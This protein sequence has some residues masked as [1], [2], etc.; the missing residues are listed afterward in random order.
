MLLNNI[1]E[2]HAPGIAAWVMALALLFA[3]SADAATDIDACGDI[4]QEGEYRLNRN[5]TNDLTCID[6]QSGNVTLD[7]A[8]FTISGEG[9]LDNYGVYVFNSTMQLTNITLSNLTVVDWTKGIVFDNVTGGSITNITASLNIDGISLYDSSNLFLASN[10][11]DQNSHAGMILEFSNNN[12][13]TGNMA[14]PGLNYGIELYSSNNNILAD[15]IARMNR[16][17]IY[18]DS[19]SNNTLKGNVASSNDENG[20]SLIYSNSSTLTNNTAGPNGKNGVYIYTANYN[21][22]IDNNAGSNSDSGIYL[23]YS[24][25]NILN[26][27]AVSSNSV[28]GIYLE[29]S[30][31]NT[32][33]NNTADSNIDQGIRL[34]FSSRNILLNNTVSNGL[35]G[36][37]VGDL[38]SGSSVIGNRVYNT[39]DQGIALVHAFN[40]IVSE[41]NVSFNSGEGILVIEGSWNNTISNN[42]ADSNGQCGGICLLNSGGSIITNNTANSNTVGITLNSSGGNILNN[43]TANSNN[44][45]GIQVVGETASYTV[46]EVPFHYIDVNKSTAN[47]I[48]YENY[49]NDYG[50][51]TMQGSDSHF[52]YELPF[53]F[54]FMGRNITRISANTNGL[55]ELLE[56]NEDCDFWYG[57][58]NYGTHQNGNH[59]GNMDA[60][61]ASNGDL[62]TDFSEDT[63]L[64]VFNLSDKVV[65]EWYGFTRTD[66]YPYGYDILSNPVH[67]QVVIYPNG[68]IEWN[69]KI[70]N[71]RSYDFDMFTGVYAKEENMEIIGGYAVDTQ[72]SLAINLS[73]SLPVPRY[74]IIKSNSISDNNLG[75]YLESSNNTIYNNYLNNSNNAVASGSNS[76]NVTRTIGS[77]I[78]DGPYLG[79]NFWA[80]PDGAGF[81]QLCADTNTDGICDSSYIPGSGNIDYLALTP[82]LRKTSTSITVNTDVNANQTIEISPDE[83]RNITNSTIE[84][85]ATIN[86]PVILK[87]NA[88]TD[89]SA[90]NATSATPVY[91]LDKNEQPIGRYIEVNVTGIDAVSLNYVNLTMYYTASDLDM[92]GDGDADDPGDLNEQTL[93]IYWY[94][95]NATGDSERWKPLGPGIEPNPDYTYIGGPRVLGGE[96]NTTADN[97]KVTLNHFSTFAL[98]A[99]IA[100]AGTSPSGAGNSGSNGGGGGVITSEPP[101]NI[102][103]A[104]KH[105]KNVIANTP[106]AYTFTAPELGIYEIDI[107]GK[108]SENDV[109]LRVEVLKGASK[110]V[111]VSPPGTVYKNLNVWAGSKRIK[112]AVIK[113]RVGNSWL[114]SSDLAAGDIRM[115]KWDGIKWAQLDTTRINGDA[116][117]VYYEATTDTFSHFAISGVK[118]ASMPAAY[119]ASQIT[120]AATHTSEITGTHPE[121]APPVRLAFII[122]V[123]AFI[124]IIA[125]LYLRK[126]RD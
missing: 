88:S 35:N 89:A 118:G 79:G 123:F 51:Y 85:N 108:E 17:G 58:G 86:A 54:P 71:F 91:G 101:G 105:E 32:L 114:N 9:L 34:Y 74:N 112:G 63:Y 30:G 5:L 116:S 53:A 6:I 27:N 107:T 40:S 25:S 117:Y 39:T 97:L 59:I 100:S 78:A 31:N 28:N 46:P 67:F 95:P 47:T 68:I 66:E 72:K 56:S 52:I 82:F 42:T 119:A 19:S 43:N 69:F 115:L 70:M 113:F 98:A 83:S 73:T 13:I 96:R 14:G 3:G 50:N 4:I 77:N 84:L 93:K 48:V 26:N 92:N 55:I 103:A 24:A 125:Y 12:I 64:G 29:Y 62:T 44:N 18:L 111:P 45:Y 124:A 21:T 15:N 126:N 104:E 23:I 16:Y 80:Q 99:E 41:N 20:I 109:S 87:I 22:L 38:S 11:L 94:N 49:I 10:V 57:C 76:L 8:G 81:S 33:I 61:F 121:E 36:I 120:P 2:G 106:V 90:L 65:V 122:G 102:A 7:G 110:L 75:I 60:I 37:V 1:Y